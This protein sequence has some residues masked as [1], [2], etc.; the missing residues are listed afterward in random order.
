MTSAEMAD[1]PDVNEMVVIHRVFRREFRAI[2]ALIRAV[3][4]GDTTRSALLADHATQMLMFLDVHHHGE[5]ELLWPVLLER[6]DLHADLVRRIAAQHDAV[7]AL[8]TKAGEQLPEW[9]AE[10]S[11]IAGESLAAVIDDLAQ[12]LFAHLD[13][14]EQQILPLVE[15]HLSV[16]EWTKLGA[17]GRS[18]LTTPKQQMQILGAILEETTPEERARMFAPMPPPVREGW[19]TKG[20]PAY[21]AYIVAVRQAG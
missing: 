3:A 7:S 15:K 18:Q 4:P 9:A 1:R 11:R 13:E 20:Q 19:T 17:H 8:I 14:E 2:P 6:V 5:D 16:D 21:D 12:T 10:P